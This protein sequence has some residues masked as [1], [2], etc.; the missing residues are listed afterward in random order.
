MDDRCS[1][2]RG[3]NT[4]VGKG[5]VAC[6]VY[7]AK[8]LISTRKTGSTWMTLKRENFE[9]QLPQSLI[10]AADILRETKGRGM[11]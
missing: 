2:A 4:S 5:C 1:Q 9:L 3:G 6:L 8:I 7:C 11:D 10:T